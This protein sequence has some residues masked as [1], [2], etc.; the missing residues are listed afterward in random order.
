[1]RT[2]LLPA[3]IQSYFKILWNK[4]TLASD[5]TPLYR[6]LNFV[7]LQGEPQEKAWINFRASKSCEHAHHAPLFRPFPLTSQRAGLGPL[8]PVFVNHPYA[9]QTLRTRLAKFFSLF[10][11]MLSGKE[12]LT[13]LNH[14]ASAYME[15]AA[16]VVGSEVP[17]YTVTME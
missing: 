16:E 1:M 10:N 9:V 6:K 12:F 17:Y 2:E 7:V 3:L 8:E 14:R 11:P 13:R 4:K 15:S 5:G